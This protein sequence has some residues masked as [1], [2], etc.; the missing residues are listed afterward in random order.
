MAT[1]HKRTAIINNKTQQKHQRHTETKLKKKLKSEKNMVWSS[2]V[3]GISFLLLV[4]SSA[5]S[6]RQPE[7][8]CLLACALVCVSVSFYVWVNVLWGSRLRNKVYD[9]VRFDQISE[10]SIILSKTVLLSLSLYVP[11]VLLKSPRP[12]GYEFLFTFFITHSCYC[13]YFF[14]HFIRFDASLRYSTILSFTWRDCVCM[15][16]VNCIGRSE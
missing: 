4:Y 9:I 2:V 14:F 3:K 7:E 5:L 15:R 1:E 16:V 10:A 11:F 8:K 12:H 6:Q 13:I